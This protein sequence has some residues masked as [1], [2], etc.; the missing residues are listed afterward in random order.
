[1][2]SRWCTSDIRIGITDSQHLPQR[3]IEACTLS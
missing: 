3:D 2:L 1:M